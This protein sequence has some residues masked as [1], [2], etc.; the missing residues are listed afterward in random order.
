MLK[1]VSNGYNVYRSLKCQKKK[2]K[3]N[4]QTHSSVARKTHVLCKMSLLMD[5]MHTD[6]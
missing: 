4:Y 6:Q 1:L 2:I 5:T 3:S